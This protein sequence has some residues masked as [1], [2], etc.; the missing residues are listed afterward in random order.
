MSLILNI[1]TATDIC[2]VCISKDHEILAIREAEKEY[3]HTSQITIL[4]EACCAA[5]GISLSQM[6]AVAVSNGPGS[7]TSL[8]VGASTAKGICYALDK[9]LISIDTLQSIALA[10]AGKE[11]RKALYAPMIDAR[12]M[13]VYTALFDQDG[14][15]VE[16]TNAKIIDEHSFQDYFEKGHTIVFSGN[17]AA[18]C[19]K[20][21]TSSQAVFRDEICSAAHLV[22]LSYP[23]YQKNDFSDPAYFSPAYF[24][25]PNITTPRKIL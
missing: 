20:V 7:Y 17:G 16:G 5:T 22:P 19:Q 15:I 13:E 1:E 14:N 3:S 9:P 21:I 24:K 12:R 23:A 10:T 8:R 11:K 4:I 18:K 6:D 2:S 25:S